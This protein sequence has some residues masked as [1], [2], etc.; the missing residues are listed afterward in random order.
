MDAKA[1]ANMRPVDDRDGCWPR[2]NAAI[3]GAEAAAARGGNLTEGERKEDCEVL[4][5]HLTLQS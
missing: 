1:L 2:N 5:R 4:L 3:S